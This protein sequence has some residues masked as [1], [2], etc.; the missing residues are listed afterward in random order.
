MT[1]FSYF[2]DLNILASLTK[3]FLR[4]QDIMVVMPYTLLSYD[5]IL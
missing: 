1:P 5:V 4:F 2:S 3:S